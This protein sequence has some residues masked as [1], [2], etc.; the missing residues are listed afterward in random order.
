MKTGLIIISC[1]W[2]LLLFSCKEVT[3][4]QP[5][6]LGVSA[7]KEVPA[8]LHGKY[9]TRDKASGEI[10]DTLIIE[11]WGYRLEDKKGID[12]LG[13]GRISDSLVVKQYQ[14]YY[15]VNFKEG[16]Q[17]V[18]RV[19]KEKSPGVLEFMSV[20]LENEV[21]RK[22]ILS[23]LS[24]TLKVKEAEQGQNTFYQINPT[25][26]QLIKLLQEGYFT[27]IELRRTR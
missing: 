1:F 7:L 11:A 2:S 16:D 15:F 4:P 26:A 8:A 18:L 25:Q 17:W 27:G 12:W 10:G 21:Q 6:P 20:N 5:Q 9:L 23:K 19:V 13:G 22:E 3:F 24:K 14:N